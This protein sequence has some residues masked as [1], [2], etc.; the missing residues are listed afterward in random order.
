MSSASTTS[1]WTPDPSTV[2]KLYTELDK[3]PGWLEL[4]W[5]CPG[6]RAPSPQGG[7]VAQPVEDGDAPKVE[8][9]DDGFDFED[10]I[11]APSGGFGT[12]QQRR[13]PGG[14]LRGSARKKTTSLDSVLSNMRRHRIIEEKEMGG[15]GD[16]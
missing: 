7:E 9:K 13:T 8:E 1:Y 5:K 16:N 2:L 10:D 3:G 4:D 15:Q 14:S 12:P 11:P 6:R